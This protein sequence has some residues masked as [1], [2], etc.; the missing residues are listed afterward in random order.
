MVWAHRGASKEAPENTLAAFRRALEAGADG[1]ELDVHLTVDGE[2]VVIHDATVDR[3]TNGRGHVATMQLEAIRALDAGTRHSATFAGERV[4]TLGEVL[5]LVL[6]WPGRR[7]VLIELKGPFSGILRLAQL[8][9]RLTGH[10]APHYAGLA[11]AVAARLAPHRAAVLEGRVVA[12]SFHRPYLDELHALLPELQLLYLSPL[13]WLETEDLGRGDS[14]LAGIA[15][16]HTGLSKEKICR[17]RK[18]HS[19]IFAWTVDSESDI[20]SMMA[21]GVDGLITNR[22]ELVIDM[23]AGRR[24]SPAPGQQVTWLGQACCCVHRQRALAKKAD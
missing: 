4:P 2:V 19:I 24:A 3:T 6:G 11:D 22:P 8:A 21:L 18:S 1:V 15:V 14:K 5:E 17:L 20:A 16:R 23:L 13:G 7:R 9:V 12:Q 10:S